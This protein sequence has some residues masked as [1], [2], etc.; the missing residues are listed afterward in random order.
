M[1]RIELAENEEKEVQIITSLLPPQ[2][3]KEEVAVNVASLYEELKEANAFEGISAP[4]QA[5]DAVVSA[6]QR[7][8]GKRSAPTGDIKAALMPLLTKD[9]LFQKAKKK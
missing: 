7:K 4:S 8:F 6:F 5:I 3:S 1:E 2:L 9:G